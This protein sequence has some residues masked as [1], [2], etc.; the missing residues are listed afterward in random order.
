VTAN[1]SL[2]EARRHLNLGIN[3]YSGRE[4]RNPSERALHLQAAQVHAALVLADRLDRLITV[5]REKP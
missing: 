1:S 2:D 3:A 4:V 5:L